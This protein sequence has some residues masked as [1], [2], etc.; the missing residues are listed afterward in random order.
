[1]PEGFDQ[2]EVL[3]GYAARDR[4]FAVPIAEP[5]VHRADEVRIGLLTT[6]ILRCYITVVLPTGKCPSTVLGIFGV[7]FVR[8]SDKEHI[9]LG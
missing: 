8:R 9:S 4:G 5:S 6:P 1:L 2:F 7:C 3:D